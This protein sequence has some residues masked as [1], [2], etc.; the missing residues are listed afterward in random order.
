VRHWLT[1]ALALLGLLALFLGHLADP[2]ALLAARDIPIFHLPLATALKEG[3]VEGLPSWNPHIHGGQPVLSN[4]NYAAFYPPTWILLLAPPHYAISLMVL[5]H[6]AAGFVGAFVFARRL[7][8]SRGPALFAGTAFAFGGA[9]L[10]TTNLLTTFCGLAWLPWILWSIDRWIADETTGWLSRKAIFP[11]CAFAL[12]FFSGQP[13][14]VMITGLAAFALALTAG[15]RRTLAIRRLAVVGALALLLATAQLLPTSLRLQETPRSGGLAAERALEWSTAPPRLLEL[16]MPRFWGDPMRIDE[17]L[18]FGWSIND[19]QYPYLVSIYSGQL[20][21]LLAACALALWR[22]RHRGAWLLMIGAGLFLALGDQNPLMAG[23]ARFTPLLSQIRY[24]EKFMLLVTSALVFAAAL[25]WQRL[26]DEREKDRPALEDFP[27]ALSSCITLVYVV[28]LVV[29]WQRPDVGEWFT[30]VHSPVI[31]GAERLESALSF[32]RSELAAGMIVSLLSCAVFALHRWRSIPRGALLWVTLLVL[33]AD[34][35]YYNRSLTPTVAAAD[36]LEPPQALEN[37][38]PASGRLFTERSIA[39]APGV[40]FRGLRPGPAAIW[41]QYENAVPY[42]AS[43]WG[44]SYAIHDDFDLMA[45]APARDAAGALESAW[46]DPIAAQRVLGAWNV[47]YLARS[48]PLE[49]IL[50]DRLENRNRGQ[51][52]VS[53][54]PYAQSRYRFEQSVTL[55]G[56][57]E[58][59]AAA[60]RAS[61][62]EHA[63][64]IAPP[65]TP[66]PT[67]AELDAEIIEVVESPAS[68]R[69]L[70]RSG[71]VAPLTIARTWHRGWRA[72]I[73]G[74]PTTTYR[75]SLGMIGVFVPPGEHLLELSFRE[76]S[77]LPAIVISLLGFTTVLVVFAVGGRRTSNAG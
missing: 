66:R 33:T 60:D 75:T 25:G 26:L 51:I 55:H 63:H 8:C 47:Q 2:D 10:A 24:P 50:E 59:A 39:G 9:S 46:R 11:A 52:S 31:P 20:V 27:L 5:L 57:S 73:D 58:S 21:I 76:P 19:R 41:D 44:F 53:E 29:L 17:D 18:Y 4:P 35:F 34:L 42:I 43:L 15:R 28:L 3:I 56:D 37:L 6:A 1:P 67:G 16:I 12:Q 62:H 7:G 74:S 54:N 13:V 45:T 71:S 65:G 32:F 38:D 61:G 64:W 69:I 36:L 22:V 70:Y 77:T 23:L 48:R 68:S 30:R 40:I 49:E 14:I 72:G